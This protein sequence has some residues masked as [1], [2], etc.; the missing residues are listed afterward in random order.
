MNAGVE[1]IHQNFE[2]GRTSVENSENPGFSFQAKIWK[3]CEDLI[4]S[5]AMV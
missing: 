1:I 5:Q 3:Y 4:E 2:T